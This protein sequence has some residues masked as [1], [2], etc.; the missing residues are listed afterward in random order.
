MLKTKEG[1]T[2]KME[3]AMKEAIKRKRMKGLDITITLG[4]APEG[5]MAKEMEEEDPQTKLDDLAPETGAL[6]EEGDAAEM[7]HEDEEQDKALFMKMMKDSPMSG[8][9]Y[10]QAMKGMKK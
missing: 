3:D 9:L 1:K 10:K 4:G 5:L 7:P 6:P 2:E 8:P